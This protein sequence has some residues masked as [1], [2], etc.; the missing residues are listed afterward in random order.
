V[1]ATDGGLLPA[2][3][4]T[5]TL[6]VVP[7]ERYDVLVTFSGEPGARRQLETIAYDR[8]QTDSQD[9]P[10][11]LLQIDQ[12]PAGAAPAGLPTMWRDLP[13]LSSTPATPVRRFVLGE[14]EL[15]GGALFFTINDEV[16]PDNAAVELKRDD[17]EI[18]DIRNESPQDHPVHVHGAFFEVLA[19][20]SGKGPA[21]SGWKDTVNVP[22]RSSVRFA[23]RFE[24]RGIWMLHCHILEHLDTGMLVN[25]I[26]ND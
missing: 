16:W 18:W 14:R 5:D 8:G 17:V 25:V 6:L 26:V 21:P 10:Q 22:R 15:A 24:T 9:G 20:A 13:R 3:Y 2:P 1:I 7:G 11:R 23:I 12:G 19:S 4:W